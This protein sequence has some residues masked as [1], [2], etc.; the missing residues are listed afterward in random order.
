MNKAQ[1]EAMNNAYFRATQQAQAE[2][3]QQAGLGA[4]YMGLGY[5]PQNQLLAQIQP[6]MTSAA[7]QQQAQ[8]YGA[9]LFGESTMSGID[10]LLAANLG[11][12]N[13]LGSAGSGLLSSL[14]A[15]S[16]EGGGILNALIRGAGDSAS[17]G[18]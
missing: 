8:L 18:P 5:M 4:Q 9:G 11:R 16:Q 7:Q 6:G 12:A 15:P 10:A 1:Q 17:T 3:A 14:F 13:L 2:Q